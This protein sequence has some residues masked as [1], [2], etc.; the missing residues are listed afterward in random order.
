[1]ILDGHPLTT[2][3]QRG[4]PYRIRE[5]RIRLIEEAINFERGTIDSPRKHKIAE[6]GGGVEVYFLKPGKE[7]LRR[8]NPNANDMTPLIGQEGKRFTFKDIW[9]FMIRWAIEDESFLGLIGML[10]YR[11]GYLIDHESGGDGKVRYVPLRPVEGVV[12]EIDSSLTARFPGGLRGFLHFIDLLGWNEDV[13]Y[14][15]SGPRVDFPRNGFCVGRINTA[16]SCLTIPFLTMN[17]IRDVKAHQGDW[18]KIEIRT[19]LDIMQRLSRSRGVCL[20]TQS[21][22]LEWLSP[23]LVRQS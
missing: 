15:S 21:E 4:E 11:I 2:Q 12:S 3:L 1:M 14:H 22:L 18:S 13:K 16:L 9:E 7:T 10:V 8:N 6:L 17:F 19:L 5:K 23:Y 20:P